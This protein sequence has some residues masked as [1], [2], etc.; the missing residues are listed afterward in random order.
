MHNEINTEIDMEIEHEGEVLKFQMVPVSGS[1]DWGLATYW[2]TSWS[3]VNLHI[4]MTATEIQDWV[5][6]MFKD[7]DRP[8]PPWAYTDGQAILDEMK[9]H[10]ESHVDL[11]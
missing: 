5:V 6:E 2:E 4:G 1:V 7:D 3:E 10:I 9:E 11:G 8:A